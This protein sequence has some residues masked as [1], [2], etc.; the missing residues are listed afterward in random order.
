MIICDIRFAS[1]FFSSALNIDLNDILISLLV[2]SQRSI[3][4]RSELPG[5]L[6]V[7]ILGDDLLVEVINVMMNAGIS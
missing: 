6:V 7:K 4:E 3:P 2:G 1:L 5:K